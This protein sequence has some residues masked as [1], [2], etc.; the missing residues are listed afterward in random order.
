MNR[1]LSQWPGHD[2]SHGFWTKSIQFCN[3]NC[4]NSTLQW[5]TVSCTLLLNLTWAVQTTGEQLG[6]VILSIAVTYWRKVYS[7]NISECLTYVVYLHILD[8]C[9]V[10]LNSPK[11]CSNF[12]Y[13]LFTKWHLLYVQRHKTFQQY[14]L[15]TIH[16]TQVRDWFLP[17]RRY[18]R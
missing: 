6:C 10:L 1:Q 14:K 9:S 18:A 2:E 5:W 11:L 17:A 15:Y 8:I 4:Q 3:A 7:L 16:K 12:I 13:F